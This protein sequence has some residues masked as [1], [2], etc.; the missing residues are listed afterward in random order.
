MLAVINSL[1]SIN[2]LMKPLGIS[3]SNQEQ[4]RTKATAVALAAL[5]ITA[6]LLGE[7]FQASPEV[8]KGNCKSFF[9]DPSHIL[10]TCLFYCDNPF[11]K[12]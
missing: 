11:P 9:E 3:F 5:F 1:K 4:I 6:Q 8:C 10:S 7:A 12:K 2:H